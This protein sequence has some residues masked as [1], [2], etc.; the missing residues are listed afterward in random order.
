ME[1]TLSPKEIQELVDRAQE[2]NNELNK[3]KEIIKELSNIKE[4]LKSISDDL[5]SYGDVNVT[6]KKILSLNYDKIA[7]DEEVLKKEYIDYMEFGKKFQALA[8]GDKKLFKYLWYKEQKVFNFLKPK[9]NGG[10]RTAPID[11]NIF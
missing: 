11:T 3:N 4:T 2:I 7:E 8:G 9:K 10:E 5:S 6:T 1:R